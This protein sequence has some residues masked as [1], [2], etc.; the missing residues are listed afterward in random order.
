V[1]PDYRKN[2]ITRNTEKIKDYETGVAL[3]FVILITGASMMAYFVFV[4]RLG[5]RLG[6]SIESI[7]NIIAWVVLCGSIGA[8]IAFILEDRFGLMKPLVIGITLHSATMITVIQVQAIPVYVV[9]TI[10]EAITMVFTLTV[11]FSIAA[12]LDNRGRWAA[13]AGG[14]FSLSL[15]VG[16]YLGGA[17]IELAGFGAL[18]MLI[19]IC[20]LIIYFLLYWISR[21]SHIDSASG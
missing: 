11:L 3:L 7:G 19:I 1:F 21:R 20:T 15:G 5:D 17:I 4:E 10:L 2:T 9:V 13:A 8:A 18:N 12:K 14:A 16:P 6:L